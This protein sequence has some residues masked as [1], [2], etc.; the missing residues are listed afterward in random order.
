MEA[1]RLRT[2]SVLDLALPPLPGAVLGKARF[3][4]DCD[5]DGDGTA[6]PSTICIGD[7]ART[8]LGVLRRKTDGEKFTPG[9]ELTPA[10]PFVAG[11]GL[12]V[13]RGELSNCSSRLS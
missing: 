2:D 3:F 4:P 8:A 6:K 7:R 10:G 5:I 11:A 1:A 13:W 12:R 9:D